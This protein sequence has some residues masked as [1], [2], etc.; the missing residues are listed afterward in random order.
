MSSSSSDPEVTKAAQAMPPPAASSNEPSSDPEST[1]W[2]RVLRIYSMIKPDT[3]LA[4]P[5]EVALAKAIV[6]DNAE[7]THDIPHSRAKALCSSYVHP[8]SQET[9]IHPLSLS[10]IL[11]M[12]IV[13]GGGMVQA[14]MTGSMPLIAASQVAN[15]TYNVLH[16][17]AN[18]NFTGDSNMQII[19]ASYVAAVSF[20]IG[21]A[22]GIE[23]IA[24][25]S[26]Y[27]KQL[28]YVGPFIAVSLATF[29]NMGLMRQEEILS[30]VEVKDE[31]GDTMGV[32]KIAGRNGIGICCGS[33]ILAAMV[34]M[35]VPTILT[36]SA[37]KGF[38]KTSPRLHVPF[39]FATLACTIQAWTPFS[40]GL[41]KQLTHM[42]VNGLEPRFQ[43]WKQRDGTVAKVAYFN[44]GM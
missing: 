23:R 12:N 41:F 40:L 34:P 36:E 29:V 11:P 22:M 32:S 43:E 13:V 31:F 33:R 35:T 17:Y 5:A 9:I 42:N 8:Q 37:K 15:Q 27:A 39:Y 38:L 16:Y 10:W 4:T 19:A 1:Y 6:F 18:R 7:P 20:S 30:G 21:G 3:V 24:R 44:R 25:A 2:K 28:R 26:K 14:S